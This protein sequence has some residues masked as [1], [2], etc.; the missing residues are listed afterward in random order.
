MRIAFLDPL[1]QRE[2]DF[3]AKYLA[4]HEVLTTNE[5]GV[6]PA[7]VETAEALVWSGFLLNSDLIGSMPNL[8]F[9]QRIG[10]TRFAGDASAA[11]ARGVAASA[12]PHGVS[13]RVAFHALA[14]TSA[15]LRKLVPGHRAVLDGLN[16][17]NLP[18]IETRQPAEVNWARVPNIDTLNDKTVG[19]IGFG[20][21]G[22]A[23]SRLLRPFDCRVLYYKRN[24]LPEATEA[25]FNVEYA[26]LEQLLAQSD[27]VASF[28]PWSEHTHRMLDDSRIRAMKPG[29]V[30]V[31][32]GRG[33]TVDET[34]LI[35]A[36]E[37]DR[38][39]GAGLDVFAIEPLPVT[40]PLTKLQ[41]VVL[42]PHS[43]GGVLGV[44][45]NYQRI[46]ENL[47]RVAQGRTVKMP[48]TLQHPAPY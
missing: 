43:A 14:L 33:N 21:I 46:A 18:E 19:I 41:N 28:L 24:R 47:D 29:A 2:Q 25:F 7:G 27:I 10:L 8:R 35:A 37:E 5:V 30:F 34:A 42:A 44:V 45:N 23:Y 6:P 32:C 39:S 15:V 48:L 17:D 36:L 13:D 3:P 16:P 12:I 31:N 9:V 20:E 1:A 4:G 22:T 40:S 26:P 38:L 11:L